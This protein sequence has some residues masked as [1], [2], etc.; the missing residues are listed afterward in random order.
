M[1]KYIALAPIFLLT[2]CMNTG[3]SGQLERWNT[4]NGETVSV[5]QMENDQAHLVIY[6][7]KNA[8]DAPAVNIFLEGDYLTSLI[9]GGY[10]DWVVCSEDNRILPTFTRTQHF[11]NRD[12][13]EAF[14]LP[15]GQTTY[16]K[17][18]LNKF[19]KPVLE[20]VQKEVALNALKDLD[21]QTATMPRVQ[22]NKQCNKKLLHKITLS[23]HSL[24][25][26]DKY[27]YSNMLLEGRREIKEVG[28]LLK[29]K[30]ANVSSIKVV[31]YTDP[32]G[33]DLYNQI[34][35]ERRANTVREALRR[36]GVSQVIESKGLGERNLV[37]TGCLDKYKGKRT[38][39]MQC[40]QPNRRVEILFYGVSATDKAE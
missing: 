13:G 11:A 6:R 21:L 27:N 18:G 2:A 40:D 28:R 23:A 33:T 3:L 34:L 35:S 4:F 9:N 1:K 5:P 26:F 38:Q 19:G 17:V 20:P 8:F 36:A 29:E 7:E 31:G 15:A 39:R 37:V 32:M 14:H 10:K 22:G 30:Y 12:T 24:F 25:K 16:M